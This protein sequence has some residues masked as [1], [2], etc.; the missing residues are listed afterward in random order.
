[1]KFKKK[2]SQALQ[3]EPPEVASKYIDEL[4][5]CLYKVALLLRFEMYNLSKSST[6]SPAAYDMLMAYLTILRLIEAH[7]II[8]ER[9]DKDIRE[10]HQEDLTKVKELK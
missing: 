1:M 3:K 5:K 2:F 10:A 6:D 4:Y 9:F 8:G 7:S